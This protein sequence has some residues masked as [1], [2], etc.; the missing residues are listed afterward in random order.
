[1]PLAQRPPLDRQRP[2]EQ[3][4]GARQ[5][6][7]VPERVGQVGQDRGDLRVVLAERPPLVR[8]GLAEE[9]L[10]GGVVALRH[11][12]PAE[13]VQADREVRMTGGEEPAA[14]DERL[15]Q[16]RL[17]LGVLAL[18]GESDA[19]EAHALG[20]QPV[21]LAEEASPQRQGLPEERDGGGEVPARPQ[22]QPEVA[23]AGGDLRVLA[24]EELPAHGERVAQQDLRCREVP[25]VAE[26]TAEPARALRHVVMGAAAVQR[27]P[28]R[29][30]AAEERLGPLVH[31]Q[32]AV[33]LADRAEHLRL[34][35]GLRRQLPLDP[36]P[37]GVEELAGGD[38]AAAR[39][40]GVRDLEEADQEVADRGGARRLAGDAPGLQRDGD[41]VAGEEGDEEGGGGERDPVAAHELPRP[42]ADAAAARR[43]R[44]AG[45]MA[46]EVLEQPVAPTE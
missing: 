45:A 9:R 13:V 19:Q 1:M 32:L 7:L 26:Q 36:P 3:R 38:V 6:A 11:Q 30:R 29:E 4:L 27:P 21:A 20:G 5:V 42:V 35:G 33:D 16:E 12:Q 14:E 17:G 2:L 39:L 18:G 37:A 23:Q 15:A 34:H 31:P 40:V 43:D 25:L 41:G 8:Q 10:G 28:L 24:A 46:L 22:Q 44:Q